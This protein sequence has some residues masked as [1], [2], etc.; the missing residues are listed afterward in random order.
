MNDEYDDDALADLH[1]QWVWATAAG[2]I[3]ALI[4]I[5]VLP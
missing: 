3:V 2:L 1:I 5:A 4:I